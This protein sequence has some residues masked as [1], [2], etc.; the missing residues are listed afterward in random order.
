MSSA[1][2]LTPNN[3]RTTRR[4]AITWRNRLR[5]AIAPVAVLDSFGPT[6]YQFQYLD[7]VSTVEGFRP[8]I[9]FP[10]FN[11]VYIS[12]RLWPFFELRA[13]DRKRPDFPEYI[14][15][16]GL[17]PEA[18]TLDIL[19]RSGG[20]N[21]GDS[22]HIVEAPAIASDG[23][24][25]A[26]FLARGVRYA[27][28][29]YGTE[30]AANSLHPGDKLLLG[31][32][33]TNEANSRALLLKTSDGDAVGW[34]PDLLVDYARAIRGGGGNVELLQ[35]NLRAPWHARLL[36]RISGRVPSGMPV[37]T[38]GVWPSIS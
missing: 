8:F 22:V 27:L 32:D 13:M 34:V 2:L 16:L 10:D 7:G 9:G 23:A 15:W 24:T 6:D 29:D 11:S 38:G 3:T 35:N 28:R 37:F 1:E 20:G 21:K 14:S 36:V 33:V 25:E 31:D 12:T 4:F 17:K 5:R 30:D 19:S 26:I 18:S